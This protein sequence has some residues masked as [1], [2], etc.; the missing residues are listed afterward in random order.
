M[1]LS[2]GRA[3]SGP[4]RLKPAHLMSQGRGG[5]QE[6]N[7]EQAGQGA[8]A[9]T[10]NHLLTALLRV[11]ARFHVPSSLRTEDGMLLP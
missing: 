8:R 11:R 4:W 2:R 10:E 5:V 6:V 9:P 7:L 1:S 3:K